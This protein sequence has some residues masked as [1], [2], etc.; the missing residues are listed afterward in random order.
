MAQNTQIVYVSDLSGVDITDN[1]QPTQTFGW[2]GTTYELDLTAKEAEKFYK[3]I[4]PY[5]DKARK[6]TGSKPARGGSKRTGPDPKEVRAWAEA[7]G[8]DVPAR[9][10]I[11]QT[12]VDQY[13]AK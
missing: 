6:V 12:I 2:D 1:D 8:I 11:P 3:T 5:L 13:N 10:R 7:Q 4:Q 9:G